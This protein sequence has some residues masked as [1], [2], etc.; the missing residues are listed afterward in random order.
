MIST[1]SLFEHINGN[2]A[3]LE[4]TENLISKL[5]ILIETRTLLSYLVLDEYS[6]IYDLKIDEQ[7]EEIK[8]NL[9]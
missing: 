3:E 7:I 8:Q 9:K 6:V 5:S 4:K 1:E 2:I